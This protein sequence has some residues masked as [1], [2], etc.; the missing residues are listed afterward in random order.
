VNVRVGARASSFVK[1]NGIN[2]HYLEEGEGEPVVLLHGSGPGVSAEANWDSTIRALATRY[3]VFAPDMVG[4]GQTDRA[5]GLDY[6][7]STWVEH[8]AG[9]LSAVGVQRANIVGNSLGGIVALFV[10]S[11]YPERVA[12]LVLMGSPGIGMR[13]TDGLRALRAYRPSLDGMRDLLQTYFTNDPS[14][15]TEELVRMRYEASALPGEQENYEAIHAGQTSRENSPLTEEMVRAMTAPTLLVHGRDDL[16][17]SPQISWT[18]S[19]LLPNADLHIFHGCGHW[20]HLERAE[21]FTH[22]VGDFFNSCHSDG[23]WS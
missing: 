20:A 13:M 19:Q 12:R 23:S 18:M 21:D 2:T 15:A 3:R 22:L 17:L 5:S 4:F 8:V 11:Q 1:V 9:F 7:L 14:V 10:A 16:V 6:R